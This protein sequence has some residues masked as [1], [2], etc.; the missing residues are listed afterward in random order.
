MAHRINQYCITDL[1][2]ASVQFIQ[3]FILQLFQHIQTYHDITMGRYGTLS[4][5]TDVTT[6]NV[7]QPATFEL[8]QSYGISDVIPSTSNSNALNSDG[9]VRTTARQT[10]EWYCIVMRPMEEPAAR[11]NS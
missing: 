8:L 9:T 2:R 5:S 3:R 6:V 7:S 10:M 1:C 11:H 4:P